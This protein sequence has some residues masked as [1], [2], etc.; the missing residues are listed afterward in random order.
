MRSTFEMQL[1]RRSLRRVVVVFPRPAD[2][3]AQG[4]IS[5]VVND[6]NAKPLKPPPWSRRGGTPTKGYHG[7]GATLRPL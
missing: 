2:R 7:G 3:S 4:R 1:G 6:E 5:G